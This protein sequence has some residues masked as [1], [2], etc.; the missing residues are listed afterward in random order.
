MAQSYHDRMVNYPAAYGHA[1]CETA[2]KTTFKFLKID[3]VGLLYDT[4]PGA[5]HS[6]LQQQQQLVAGRDPDHHRALRSAGILIN[7]Y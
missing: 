4:T 3:A 5:G 6:N 1:G 7:T 2:D